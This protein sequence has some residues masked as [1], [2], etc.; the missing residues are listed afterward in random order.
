M[1]F[2]NCVFQNSPSPAFFFPVSYEGFVLRLLSIFGIYLFFPFSSV[3]LYLVIIVMI[4]C[5]CQLDGAVG[6]QLFG[7]TL[8]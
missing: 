5:M 7:H 6:A 1:S 2:A 3:R 8:F 4:N